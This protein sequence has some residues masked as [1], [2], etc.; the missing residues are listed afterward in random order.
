MNAQRTHKLTKV[1]QT[2]R[3][4]THTEYGSFYAL[5]CCIV[6]RFLFSAL[7]L[8]RRKH[9]LDPLTLLTIEND[10][11]ALFFVVRFFFFHFRLPLI[12][13]IYLLILPVSNHQLIAAVKST[14]VLSNLYTL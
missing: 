10:I 5:L 2:T 4:H 14:R 9:E 8:R 12:W 3:T 6:L 1:E 13:Y 11:L 7:S